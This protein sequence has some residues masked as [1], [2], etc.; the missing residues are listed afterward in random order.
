MTCKRPSGDPGINLMITI[1]GGKN[2][3]F[4]ETQCYN[5][6]FCL[7]DSN[8]SQNRHFFLRF[9]WGGGKHIFKILTSALVRPHHDFG[10]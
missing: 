2:G 6:L 4:L 5:H 9:F 1:V 7:N 3:V 8:L 10:H